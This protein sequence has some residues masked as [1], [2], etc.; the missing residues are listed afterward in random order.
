MVTY[1]AEGAILRL[2]ISGD[3]TAR[4][5]QA[6]FDAIRSDP[7]VPPGAALLVDARESGITFKNATI[8]TRLGALL[9]GLGPKFSKVCAFIEPIHDPLYG[10]AF[11]RAGR[12]N[13][14]HIGLFK[15]DADALRWL[16]PYV[17]DSPKS[18]ELR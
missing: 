18:S 10:K 3:V 7:K 2:I 17:K 13:G 14:V 6:L 12:K 4:E 15:D 9:D 5:R 11:Q 1:R 8:E 16:A